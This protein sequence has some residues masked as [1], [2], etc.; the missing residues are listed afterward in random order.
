MAVVALV[1]TSCGGNP[2]TYYLSQPFT[3]VKDVN[4]QKKSLSRI[5]KGGE[6]YNAL[7]IVV[8]D[9]K[10]VLYTPKG[11]KSFFSVMDINTGDHLGEFGIKGNGPMES[12]VFDIIHNLDSKNGDIVVP[13]QD[14]AKKRSLLCNVTKTL[15]NNMPVYD[16]IVSCNWVD[17]FGRFPVFYSDIDDDR[18][19]VV[20]DTTPIENLGRVIT[21]KFGVISRS[22][23]KFLSTHRVFRD[24]VE[25][26]GFNERWN[27]YM[28]FSCK[29]AIN[30]SKTKVAIGMTYLPQINILDVESGDVK[31]FRIENSPEERLTKSIVYYG[32]IQ[33]DDKLIYALYQ[34]L[35]SNMSSPD[36]Y[37]K[38]Q[39]E[40]H[41][42]NWNGELIEK[43]KLDR[44]YNSISVDDGEIYGFRTYDGTIDEYLL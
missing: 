14:F 43:W 16:T 36:D 42:F 40:L 5:V 44:F 17:D 12:P 4:I 24:S 38:Y 11:Y 9:G 25:V 2:S 19:F 31:C 13:I 6:N 35:N 7:H 23:K 30:Q 1:Y 18:M 21:P 32:S 8:R 28:P 22:E 3:E 34:N 33:C 10:C 39:S 26:F 41:I 15:E 29:C 37:H 27:P 20:L